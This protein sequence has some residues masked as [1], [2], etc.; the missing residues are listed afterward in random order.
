MNLSI[1]NKIFLTV[2][3]FLIFSLA[4]LLVMRIFVIKDFRKYEEG[5]I[6]D[7]VYWLTT[8]LESR[9]ERD[10]RLVSELADETAISALL[11][12]FELK[13]YD[14]RGDLITD[15]EQAVNHAMPLTKR[16]IGRQIQEIKNSDS[17]PDF[18]GYPLFLANEE[19]GEVQLRY[20][21]GSK[22][23][24]FL[25]RTGAFLGTGLIIAILG[26]LILSLMLTANIL[27][28][29]TRLHRAAKNLSEDKGIEVIENHRNDELGE[30]AKAF[31]D[32]SRALETREKVR[33]TSMAKFAHELRTPLTIMQGELEGMSD[34]V[35]PMTRE[36][37]VSLQEEL[38]RLKG[39]TRAL[40]NL[41]RA[42]RDK[43]CLE[44]SVCNIGEVL[45]NIVRRF[46]PRCREKGI[47]IELAAE[48]FEVKT[49][50]AKLIQIVINLISNAM[51]ATEKGSIKLSAAMEK[52]GHSIKVSDTGKGIKEEDLPY[53]FERFYGSSDRGLGLG[54]AIVKELLDAL[55]GNIKVT[56]A[57][58][59]GTTFALFFRNQ[60]S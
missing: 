9:Y 30:L 18:V 38:E 43:E 23:V 44:I 27:V 4:S 36:R 19:I 49:D 15:T 45:R 21:G 48:D 51:D 6:E 42:E 17:P 46:E 40:E 58:G 22:A 25:S 12:G 13:L 54:L 57:V 50:R 5:R 14:A 28:P 7:K 55:G 33:K 32:M 41:Y 24:K 34:G 37:M 3:L 35:V 10:G 52:G 31:N 60:K 47:T 26:S 59:Q 39:M 20:L 53:V 11:M 56:S 1:R 2:L 16:R 29:I 8:L